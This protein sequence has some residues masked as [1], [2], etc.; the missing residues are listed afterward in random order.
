MKCL[1]CGDNYYAESKHDYG[2]CSD[3]CEARDYI[4]TEGVN[5]VTG[6]KEKAMADVRQAHTR[7]QWA[8]TML[9]GANDDLREQVG[10]AYQMG[11]TLAEM[12]RELGLS[13]QRI[14]GMLR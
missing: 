13:R 6:L 8:R 14:H 5:E 12:G 3:D 2:Y 4:G 7:V 11:V 1:T 10:T 9:A